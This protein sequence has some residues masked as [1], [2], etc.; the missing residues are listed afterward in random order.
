MEQ[1]C[2]TFLW[3]HQSG[4]RKLHLIS[5]D[6]ITQPLA[7]GG[8]G[9]R[10]LRELNE[11]FL[12]KLCWGLISD[13]EALWSQVLIHK[14]EMADAARLK[15]KATHQASWLWHAICDV[16]KTVVELATKEVLEE[17][18]TRCVDYYADRDRGWI[19]EYFQHS[20]PMSS[21]LQIAAIP[22]PSNDR[23]ADLPIW[24]LTSN[25]NFSI[26][27][28]YD[29]LT[30][31]FTQEEKDIWKVVW[32]WKG[33]QRVKTFLWLLSHGKLLTNEAWLRRNLAPSTSCPICQDHTKSILHAI[34]DCPKVREMWKSLV[35][36][37]AWEQFFS[38]PIDRWLLSNIRENQ[39]GVEG[40]EWRM[41]F[42]VGCWLMWKWRNHE[43]F[44]ENFTRPPNEAM[45]VY[46]VAVS[47][48]M[49]ILAGETNDFSPNGRMWRNIS[50]LLPSNGWIA[51]NTDGTSKGNLG[52][53]GAGSVIKDTEGRWL[54][55][56]VQNIGVA[57][58]F[59][60][61]LWAI[62]VGLLMAWEKGYRRVRLQVDSLT[63]V[64][65]LKTGKSPRSLNSALFRDIYGLLRRDWQVEMQHIYREANQC[66]D[67][68]ANI[69]LGYP[70][71][72]HWLHTCPHELE[73]MILGD[74]IGA[75][76][77]RL[78]SM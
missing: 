25:G 48:H 17:A 11:V 78:V 36:R 77:P 39:Q 61:E 41:L 73:Y 45:V 46:K 42:V 55:G 52:V 38:N 2:R 63:I 72:V 67:R 28:A 13:R 24:R 22:T 18:R 32:K 49:S 1:L 26:K 31:D 23:G 75:N 54:D 14:Y 58:S 69:A 7:S 12:A 19:W 59:V 27:S 30:K 68:L 70:L 5:W 29:L 44:D 37:K 9:V 47:F 57:T 40:V 3:G 64:S 8:L 65:M 33:P 71:G 4:T 51:L 50:W 35:P 15:F 16:W 56:F 60:A 43:V 34:R 20:L 53:A 66:A 74:I 62:K 21:L 10:R 76:V 6:T